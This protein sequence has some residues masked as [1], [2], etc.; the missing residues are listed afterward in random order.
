V[1]GIVHMMHFDLIERIFSGRTLA[2]PADDDPH[3]SLRG[4]RYVVGGG[5]AQHL[6]GRWP[7]AGGL[8]Q[9]KLRVLYRP[10]FLRYEGD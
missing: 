1:S 6:P 2:G 10:G 3:R 7:G 4:V 8:L 5:Y 9:W